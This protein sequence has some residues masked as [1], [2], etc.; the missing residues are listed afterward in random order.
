MMIIRLPILAILLTS[1]MSWSG[2]AGLLDYLGKK[3]VFICG[4]S[5]GGMIP[6]LALLPR[7][8]QRPDFCDTAVKI[9]TTEMGITH[10]HSPQ[11]D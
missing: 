3:K 1:L 4:L 11:M 5:V 6:V 10:A 8:D 2:L 9:G 7:S